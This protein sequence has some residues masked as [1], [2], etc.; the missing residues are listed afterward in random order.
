MSDM[1]EI[2]RTDETIHGAYRAAVPGSSTPAE[3][4]WRARGGARIAEHTFTP[5]EARGKGI[6]QALVEALIED[7]RA[8]GFTIVPACSYVAAQF[9]RHPEWADLLA[10]TAS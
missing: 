10:P 7:A 2:I 5:P 4:T 6:A 3:L 8:E 1:I 9:K